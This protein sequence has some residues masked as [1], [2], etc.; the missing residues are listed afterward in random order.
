MYFEK[1]YYP[2]DKNN[3]HKGEKIYLKNFENSYLKEK[4]VNKCSKCSE[5]LENDYKSKC[6]ICNKVYC[7][8][9]FKDDEHIK[10]D[11]NNIDIKKNF[12]KCSNHNSKLS[13]YC[14]DCKKTYVRC[15]SKITQIIHI[16]I[17]I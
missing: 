4:T 2:R 5:I 17:I 14:I 10:M 11:I 9:C 3:E 12:Q 8:S 1:F 15:V 6:K 7:F 13:L 16:K